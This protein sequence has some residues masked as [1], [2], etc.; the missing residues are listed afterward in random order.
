VDLVV[1]QAGIHEGEEG[2][3]RAHLPFPAEQEGEA[4]G[5]V[6][7]EGP[8][9]PIGP[10]EDQEELPG[11]CDH[12]VVVVAVVGRDGR[13]GQKEG[14]GGY[15]WT[16]EV[17][18]AEPTPWEEAVLG[19]D[20]EIR[21][22]EAHEQAEVYEIPLDVAPLQLADHQVAAVDCDDHAC[23]TRERPRTMAT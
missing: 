11:D 2:E 20:H 10:L 14:D 15:T 7:V 13:R 23:Q 16:D 22:E 19:H 18:Q 3:E 9:A 21:V 17:R 8:E 5:A 12:N 6:V 1:L 4:E